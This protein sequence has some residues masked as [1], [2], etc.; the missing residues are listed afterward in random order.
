MG[1]A[2]TSGGRVF[3]AGWSVRQGDRRCTVSLL[4]EVDPTRQRV[5]GQL[6]ADEL[7]AVGAGRQAV[8]EVS[9]ICE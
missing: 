7:A 2:S 8:V 1:S 3:L 4:Q 5:F 6:A 9:A